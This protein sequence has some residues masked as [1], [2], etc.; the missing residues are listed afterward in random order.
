MKKHV[1]IAT[2]FWKPEISGVTRA[3]EDLVS[4]LEKQG[5]TVAV[6]HPKLFTTVPL[7]FYPN[8]K[9]ALTT[10]RIVNG[11]FKQKKPDYIYIATE[12]PV[13]LA[14]RSYCLARRL[15]FITCYQ[16]HIPYYIEHY[17][18]VKS[19]MVV[20][21][22]YR[23]FKWFHQ[24]SRA[25][26]VTTKSLRQELAKRGFKKLVVSP[27]GVDTDFFKRNNTVTLGGDSFKHPVFVYLGRIAKEKN[28]EEFLQ[29][30]LPGTKLVI[31]DGPE[32]LLLEEKYKD[33]RFVGWKKG[34]DLADMLSACDVFVFPSITE[35]FGL[36]IIEALACGIP[37]AAHK[38]MG[39]KDIITHG[40]DG[41]LGKDLAVSAAKCLNLSKEAC[42]Q[43]AL[44][45][46]AERSF[47]SFKKILLKHPAQV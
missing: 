23:Y 26:I 30:D 3:I 13:G 31:G 43:K 10:K 42:R 17:T 33:V 29:S 35:T 7:F 6:I 27:L 38:V 14:V 5:F 22:A 12:G 15:S 32:R 39:P 16:T 34:K 40:V 37:V 21:M 8:V 47:E 4:R 19:D 11:I 41:F 2:D 9:I 18:G 46:S 36:V 44:L 1:I 28:I 45:F 25:V 20:R 24:K